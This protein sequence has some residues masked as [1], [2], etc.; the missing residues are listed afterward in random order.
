MRAAGLAAFALGRNPLETRVIFVHE[1]THLLSRNALGEGLPAWLDEGM[2]EDLAWCRTDADG[3]APAGHAGR[4]RVRRAA[5]PGRR[6]SSV[7]ALASART[8]GSRA[9]GSGAFRPLSALLAPGSRLLADPGARRDA[10][11]QSAMLVRFCL[12]TP[13]RAS[14]FP[15]VSANRLAR[16]AGRREVAR[17]D[18]RDGRAD[19]FEG[20]PEVGA[21]GPAGPMK[22]ATRISGMPRC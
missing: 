10:A 11:S 9:P 21:G 7:P 4:P 3:S 13:E 19:A 12:A 5:R 1:L 20:I 2:A 14:T 18:A 8:T 6:P 15:G 22:G 16:R 17:R